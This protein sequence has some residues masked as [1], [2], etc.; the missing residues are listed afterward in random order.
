MD[1]YSKASAAGAHCVASTDAFAAVVV[2][3]V[4]IYNLLQRI[5]MLEF[6][7]LQVVC[8]G[9]PDYMGNATLIVRHIAAVGAV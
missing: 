5:S 3:P 1:F 2:G 7:G 8:N 4:E 9:P 6:Y